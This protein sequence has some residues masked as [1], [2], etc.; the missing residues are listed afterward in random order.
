MNKSQTNSET[1]IDENGIELIVA[2]EYDKEEGFYEEPGNVASFVE[3]TVS[4]TLTSV[5]LIIKGTGI[6]VL[7]VLNKKQIDH[8]I[9]KLDYEQHPD[10]FKDMG[11]N[12]DVFK[13][14]G[15]FFEPK[16][17]AQC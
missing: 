8:I 12:F 4:T 15:E 17:S 6:D 10:L 5:E 11:Q 3:A 14:L 16:K 9:S 7:P 2:Y 1:L 13:K